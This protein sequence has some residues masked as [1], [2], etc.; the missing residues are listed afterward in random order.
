MAPSQQLLLGGYAGQVQQTVG[1]L[2]AAR[3]VRRLWKR[4]PSLWSADSAA[5]AAIRQR[6]GWLDIIDVMRPQV[7]ALRVFAADVRSAGMTQALLLGMGGSGLFPEICRNTFGV[8]P[9]GLD[10]A[11]LDTTDPA[12]ILA[13]QQRCSAR[14]TLVIVSSKSG[15]TSEVSALS[16]H[17]YEW[18][19]STG[20]PAGTRCIAI[21]DAGTSLEAQAKSWGFRRIFTHGQGTGAEVGGRFSA[22]TY[23]GLVPAALLGIDVGALLGRA[24]DMF[25]ACGPERPEEENPGVQLGAALGALGRAGLDK[26]TFICTPGLASFGTWVE[27][28]I[29]ESTGKVGRGLVPIYGEPLRPPGAY[30]SDRVFVELQLAGTVDQALAGHVDALAAGGHPVIR[31]RWQDLDDLG[32]EVAKWCVA[33]TAAARLLE[34]NPFDEPN[35]QESKDRTKALLQQYAREG[36]LTDDEHERF[37]DADVAVYGAV[38]LG[39]ATSLTQC[40]EAL[41]QQLRPR[42]YIAL[43]SFLPRTPELDRTMQSLRERVALRLG[44]ATMLQFGPRYLHSTGQLYKGGPDTG[45]FLQFTD[46][47]GED[48]PIPGEPFSFATLKRAQALGDF[49]AMQQRGRRVL[50]LHIRGS[51]QGTIQRVVSAVDEASSAVARR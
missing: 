35:V 47:G 51:L 20:E 24:Q 3:Y 6:L 2:R 49:Q 1:E 5:Q 25:R 11:V 50:R 19:A 40:L 29:A 12:A 8:A 17:F 4:D 37:A 46:E 34:I 48:L 7:E 26:L 9:G 22:L 23:F 45:L 31:I 36:R 33:T 30:T 18:L 27:Q 32:A 44:Y 14:Q 28:L 15:S 39:R 13:R 16:K 21:S 10:L 42:D 38:E 43:L 41:F